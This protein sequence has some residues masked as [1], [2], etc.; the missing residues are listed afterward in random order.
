M[1]NLETVQNNDVENIDINENDV[2]DS[3]NSIEET[4]L[5]ENSSDVVSFV[6]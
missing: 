6:L 5:T 2:F 3:N 4:D 1:E